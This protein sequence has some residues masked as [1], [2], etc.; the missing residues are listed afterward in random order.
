MKLSGQSAQYIGEVAGIE[1]IDRFSLE[2]KLE[3][4]CT[5]DPANAHIIRVG[6]VFTSD[7]EKGKTYVFCYK[8]Q[9][10]VDVTFLTKEADSHE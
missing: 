5:L 9:D 3:F 7:K 6:F 10:Y 1:G 2:K 4:V 8:H